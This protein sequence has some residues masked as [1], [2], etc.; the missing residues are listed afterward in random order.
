MRTNF[1][2]PD[3]VLILDF[4][5][6]ASQLADLARTRYGSDVGRVQAAP[7]G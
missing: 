6:A 4:L 7:E 1:G 2:R 3:L 5:H